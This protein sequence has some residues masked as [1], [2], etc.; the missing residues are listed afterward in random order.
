MAGLV[1]SKYRKEF[2]KLAWS[3]V[4]LIILMAGLFH[5]AKIIRNNPGVR[6]AILAYGYPGIFF[7]SL[8]SGFNIAV[9]IPAIAFLPL[10][11]ESGLIFGS[12]LS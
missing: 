8:L 3:G 1:L 7:I 10:F 12:P 9:P 5:L 11:L 2:Q 6:D 4:F